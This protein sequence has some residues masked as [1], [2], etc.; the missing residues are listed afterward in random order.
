MNIINIFLIIFWTLIIPFFLGNLISVALN[1]DKEGDFSKNLMFG[2]AICFGAFYIIVLPLL[3]LKLSF[4]LVMYLWL[5]VILS[6]FVFSLFLF[7]KRGD[8]DPY[9]KLF[10]GRKKSSEKRSLEGNVIWIAA[11]VCILSQAL[12]LTVRMHMDTDDSRFI[13]EAMEAYERNTMLC[14]NPITGNYLGEP[15]GE[16]LKDMACPYPIFL[17]LLGRLFMLPPAIVAHTVLPA[18]YIPFSY[19]VFYN[20]I[21]LFMKENRQ[22]LGASLLFLS[23][24]Y[25]FYFGTKAS[26]GYI[27]LEIIWQ[28]RSLV[29]VVL[30]P[31]VW[32]V[33]IR[34]INEDTIKKGLYLFLFACSFMACLLSGM[35]AVTMVL[36]VLG[37]VPVIIWKRGSLK[38]ALPILLSLIPNMFCLLL[39]TGKFYL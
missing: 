25:Y 19:L 26:T 36:F 24:I 31:M 22:A 9:L 14:I 27:L 11:I 10:K 8:K 16:M 32:Y 17:A 4:S 21:K 35:G 33:M 2:A 15:I 34:M 1:E 6:L 12:L 29:P 5:L 7:I 18:L 3:L 23:L 30:L 20:V 28:G 13:A 38:P 37:H 39:Y